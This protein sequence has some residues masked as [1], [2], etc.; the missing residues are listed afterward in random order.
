MRVVTVSRIKPHTDFR[1]RIESGILKMLVIGL[2]KRP[3]A[4]QHH[5]YGIRGLRDMMPESAKVMFEKTPFVAA[6]AVLE[7]AAEETAKLQVVAKS[8]VFEVEPKLLDEARAL[9][10]RAAIRPTRSARDRRDRQK[11][12]RGRDRSECRRPAADRTRA[13]TRVA[14]DHPHLRAGP[15]PR[16]SRQRHRD[17]PGRPHDPPTRGRDRPGDFARQHDHGVFPT[18][19]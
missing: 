3:G 6:L 8:E 9:M 4:A 15:L 14:A 5:R 7:N 10:G 2:G 13:G 17:R 1:G 18:P 16:E 11:L 12:L 19:L